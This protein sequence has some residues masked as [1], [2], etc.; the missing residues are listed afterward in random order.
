MSY[1]LT[2]FR[3]PDGMEASEAYE[4]LMEREE[5]RAETTVPLNEAALADINHLVKAIL[6]WRPALAVGVPAPITSIQ[7]NDKRLEVQIEVHP[8]TVQITMPY[9]RQPVREMMECAVGCIETVHKV[10]G[11]SAYDPQ[12]D[13]FVTAADLEQMITR[14][15]AVDQSEILIEVAKGQPPAKPWWKFW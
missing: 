15:C 1:D 13:H 8:D 10:A 6:A 3:V 2:L 9:F 4:Q 12:A 11:Y 5:Q 7:L 14:Y